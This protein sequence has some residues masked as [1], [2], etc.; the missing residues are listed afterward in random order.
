MPSGPLAQPALSRMALA[1]SMLNSYFVVLDRER[2]G[3]AHR[4]IGQDRMLGLEAGTLAVDLGPGIGGVEL[5][6]LDAAAFAEDHAALAA[7]LQARE[8]LVLDLHVPA[9]VELAGL[10]YRA[11]GRCRV[12]AALH[13]DG[14][15][16]LPLQL[17]GVAEDSH[18]GQPRGLEVQELQGP[19]ADRLEIVR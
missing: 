8:D 5:D 12:A 14:V 6:V 10:Q 11:R 9:E 16:I 15:E 2:Q 3:L 18:A 7:L 17:V 13:L 19:G 4:R 1:L